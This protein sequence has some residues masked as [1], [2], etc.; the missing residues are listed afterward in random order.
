MLLAISAVSL[1]ALGVVVFYAI[2]SGRPRAD[3]TWDVFAE[4]APFGSTASGCNC[5]DQSGMTTAMAP[6]IGQLSFSLGLTVSVIDLSVAPVATVP[7]DDAG[8]APSGD[9]GVDGDDGGDF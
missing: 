3:G 2:V 9:D 5:T 8:P 7:S 6:A 4:F 1:A